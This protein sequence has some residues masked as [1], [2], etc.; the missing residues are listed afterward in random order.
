MPP[1]VSMKIDKAR[2]IDRML[3]V[4]IDNS[5][6]VGTFL[7]DPGDVSPQIFQTETVSAQLVYEQ[8]TLLLMLVFGDFE[9]R[10]V[11]CCV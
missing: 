1:P 2:E 10:R 6:I 11:C 9:W 5:P 7:T 3:C 4:A 8:V